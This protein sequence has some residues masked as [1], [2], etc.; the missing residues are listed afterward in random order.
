MVS[1]VFCIRCSVLS[2][3]YF[4]R[5]PIYIF[6]GPLSVASSLRSGV[7]LIP[8][9]Q[10]SKQSVNDGNNDQTRASTSH[11]VNIINTRHLLINWIS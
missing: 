3:T 10:E 1:Y 8:D 2:I 6:A 11:T 7:L 5:K 4:N 9:D